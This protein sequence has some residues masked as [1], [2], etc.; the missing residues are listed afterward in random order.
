MI[1]TQKFECPTANGSF[2]HPVQ[3]DK[4]YD[5]KDDIAEEVLCSDGLV[6]NKNLTR[7][8]KCDQIF[9]VD[10]GDRTKLREFP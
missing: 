1:N 5:C 2:P 7:A 10:C 6:F 9:N 4:Y 3:C 8:G